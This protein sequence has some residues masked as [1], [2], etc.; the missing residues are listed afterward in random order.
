MFIIL[1]MDKI[2]NMLLINYNE[3]NY[4]SAILSLTITLH[5]CL[6][7]SL[8]NP[9]AFIHVNVFYLTYTFH[10]RNSIHLIRKISDILPPNLNF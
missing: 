3:Q 8:G 2:Y 7:I 4:F 1:K 5:A 9:V 6:N 10:R